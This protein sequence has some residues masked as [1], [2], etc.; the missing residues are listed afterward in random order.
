M[1]RLLFV[2]LMASAGGVSGH[3]QSAPVIP[4]PGEMQ[5]PPNT[6]LLQG[7]VTD[8]HGAPVNNATVL[9][10]DS[11]TLQ[12]RS[13]LASANGHYQFYGLSSDVNYEVRAETAGMTSPAK[14]IS[15]FDSHKIIKVDLKIKK[16]KK[17]IT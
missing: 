3:A 6:R 11:K 1:M 9:L 2:L 14:Q 16:P 15:V 5:I 10:K 17:K 13:Y 7:T 8:A 4:A 12:V